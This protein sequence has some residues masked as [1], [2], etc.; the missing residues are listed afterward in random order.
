MTDCNLKWCP[1]CH[2]K[3]Q[4]W[5]ESNKRF[6]DIFKTMGTFVGPELSKRKICPECAEKNEVI[7]KQVCKEMGMSS[8]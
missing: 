4:E 2:Y 6:F 8:L 5:T 3:W 7:A 1:E